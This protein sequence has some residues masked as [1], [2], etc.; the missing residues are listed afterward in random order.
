MCKQSVNDENWYK[1][2]FKILKVFTVST[3]N[4]FKSLE[5]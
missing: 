4:N 5:M 2:N 3:P 1:L